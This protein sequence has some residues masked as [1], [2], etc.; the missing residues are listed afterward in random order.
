[1]TNLSRI[2]REMERGFPKA[3]KMHVHLN[4]LKETSIWITKYVLLFF[5]NFKQNAAIFPI[6][7]GPWPQSQKGV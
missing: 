2:V 7:K 6:S 5:P 1:M 4:M 3:L